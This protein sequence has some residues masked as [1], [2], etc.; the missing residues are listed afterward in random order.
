MFEE[1]NEEILRFVSDYKLNIVS[2]AAM[3]DLDFEKFNTTM[4]EL[5]KFLK[6]SSDKLTLKKVVDDD[7]VYSNIDRETAELA[8]ELTGTNHKFEEGKERVDM[9]K[10]IDD[11]CKDAAQERAVVIAKELI[12]IGQMSIDIIAQVTKLPINEVQAL[13]KLQ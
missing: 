5:F 9:C 4:A 3:S 11:M 12:S 8:N 13:A 7:N 2:P 6:Y 10:A 1:G